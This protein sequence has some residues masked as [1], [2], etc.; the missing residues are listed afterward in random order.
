MAKSTTPRIRKQVT[1]TATPQGGQ[2][3]HQSAARRIP[4][5][6]SLK[7]QLFADIFD[8]LVSTARRLEALFE[9][10]GVEQS[11]FGVEVYGEKARAE[12]QQAVRANRAW[13][14]LSALYDYAIDGV[15]P[16][17]VPDASWDGA[18]SLVID[19][20]EVLALLTG[21]ENWPSSQWQDILRMADGRVALEEGT[22][23]DIERI[24]LLADVDIRTVRNAIS[25]GALAI[26]D[27]IGLSERPFPSAGTLIA[28][29]DALAWLVGRR[30]YKHS[31]PPY[32][33]A[34]SLQDIGSALHLGTFL[35][36]RR[37]D[38]PAPI[39]RTHIAERL[40][41]YPALTLETIN[42]IEEGSLQIPLHLVIPL[43]DFYGVSR[44]DLLGTVMRVFYPQELQLLTA[45]AEGAQ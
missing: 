25:S 40:E 26:A 27:N 13:K 11:I 37:E 21:E 20:G 5:G 1:H 6:I 42:K 24:A 23:L 19:A 2:P 39:A 43:A 9:L 3:A 7:E 12:A 31:V 14:L 35:R 15:H 38:G 45:T 30:G 10:E 34:G 4:E 36:Q 33:H 44:N 22:A 8:N 32:A 29:A 41:A 28:S 18:S 16:D 17:S